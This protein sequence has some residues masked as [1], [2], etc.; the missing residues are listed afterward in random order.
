[1]SGRE[2]S[3]SD[4][5]PGD[6]DE[7]V[8]QLVGAV[9][10]R[11]QRDADAGDELI[12]SALKMAPT[13]L[14]AFVEGRAL[15]PAEYVTEQAQGARHAERGDSLTRMDW[16]LRF[17]NDGL[18]EWLM[19]ALAGAA[20]ELAPPPT[21][22]AIDLAWRV[23]AGRLEKAMGSIVDA[24]L[25][26]YVDAQQR[27]GAHRGEAPQGIAAGGRPG[28]VPSQAL[29]S[30]V[31]WGLLLVGVRAGEPAPAGVL[32]RAVSAVAGSLPAAVSGPAQLWPCVHTVIG[33]PAAAGAWDRAVKRVDAIV[34]HEPVVVI[35]MGPAQGSAL[36]TEYAAGQPF[37]RL[38][39]VFGKPGVV[40]PVSLAYW[41]LAEVMSAMD[42]RAMLREAPEEI[43]GM[44][45]EQGQRT[46]ALLVELSERRFGLTAVGRALGMSDRGVDKQLKAVER[47]TGLDRAGA[48]ERLGLLL[49]GRT[50]RL[51][52]LG[53]VSLGGGDAV[54]RK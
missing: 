19:D 15:S 33:L 51:A 13:F 5:P 31:P 12:V 20:M 6:F 24:R 21:P 40:W 46:V 7:A 3:P 27:H 4:A 28:P 50:L 16:A 2:G 25:G 43:R 41:R 8:T 11:M 26:G 36:I 10:A 32:R 38:A 14:L 30:G 49:L 23:L 42:R 29:V 9:V 37:V 47:R 17:L 22:G 1:M 48:G 53:L 45:P 18:A 35:P 39:A 34:G 44:P 54:W 52:E